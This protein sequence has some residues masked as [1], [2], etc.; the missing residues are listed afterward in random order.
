MS[1]LSD[2]P[3]QVA[4]ELKQFIKANA[5]TNKQAELGVKYYNGQHDILD[6]RIFW[7][8]EN[9]RLQEDKS[10]SNIRIPHQFMTELVDQ[11]VQF[12]LSNGIKP[13]ADET[14]DGLQDFLDAYYNEDFMQSV[15]DLITNASQKGFEYLYAQADATGKVQFIVADG[16]KI[17]PLTD[18]MGN[19]VKILRVWSED[20]K[21][22]N[23]SVTLTHA[24]LYDQATVTYFIQQGNANFEIDPSMQPNPR[25]HVINTVVVGNEVTQ[26]GRGFGTIPFYRFQNNIAEKTD[27]EPIKPLIDDYD[28]MD[29]F[30]SNNLQD[31]ADAIY[32]FRGEA[33]MDAAE[34]RMNIKAKKGVITGDNNYDFD[35]KTYNI[36]VEGRRTKMDIDRQNIYKF[37]MGVDSL[38]VG[39]GNITNV[40]IMSRYELLNM[41]ANKLETRVRA[42]LKWVNQLVIND[43]N[44]INGT[45]YDPADVTFE[46]ERKM[47]INEKDNADT[48]KT[49]ADTLSVSIQVLLSVAPYID[50]E[51]MLRQ[52]ADKFDL[53]YEEVANRLETQ[54]YG[55][56]GAEID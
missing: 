41:K 8:D 30:M 16:L 34:M 40:V 12:L 5:V 46:M 24:E 31:M 35:M 6:N 2:S 18:S 9:G 3:Q 19:V 4:Q 28:L 42:L 10:A 23:R 47:L 20:V 51:T 49:E 22:D 7:I 21:I 44:R 32:V 39:D 13:V 14:A 55:N 56:N 25:P 17:Y 37:G 45:A 54:E 1:I 26:Q 36:P 53:D 29:A 15:E 11:K 50:K 52:I 48:K 33:D 38:Q 43:I 27:L